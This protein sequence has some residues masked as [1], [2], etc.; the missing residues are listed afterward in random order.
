MNSWP[1][2]K[3]SRQARVYKLKQGVIE[4]SSSTWMVPAV[5]VPKKLGEVQLCVDY[6]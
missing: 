5:F 2:Q 4:K 1:L 6:H 3:G